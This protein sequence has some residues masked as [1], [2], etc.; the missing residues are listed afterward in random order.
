MSKDPKYIPILKWKAAEMAALANESDKNKAHITPLIELVLPSVNAHKDKE[1]K[2]KKTEEEIHSEMVNKLITKR[3]FEI[4]E[5]IYK[6]W[7]SNEV[8]L[9]VTLLHNKD[10]TNEL[11]I[12][13]LNALTKKAKIKELNIIPVIN[14]ADDHL[15]IDCVI[16]LISDQ[17]IN[18]VCLRITQSSLSDSDV[19]NEK[20]SNF[21]NY[22]NIPKQKI[23]ILIDLKYLNP[24]SEI[25]SDLFDCAQKI[26][27]LKEFKEFIFSSGSFP[28]D[29]SDCS[30]EETAYLPRADWNSWKINTTKKEL[31]R[32]PVYSDYSI[33]H[34]IYNDSLQFFESTST[35][36]YTLESEWMIM[37]GKKRALELYLTHAYLLVKQPEFKNATFGN[38]ARFSWGDNQ[39]SKKA[40][41]F[42][43]Y[44]RDNSVK[45]MGR[46]WDW[47]AFGINHHTAMVMHQ[48][49]N[50]LD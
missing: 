23:H 45:G 11:K 3:F 33:R 1:R 26:Y 7:G 34:P 12:D 46:T 36:K 20:I 41:H 37:K 49:S 50:P 2:K 40:Q 47:I 25:Y 30:L 48:L 27:K 13:A 18:E 21:I 22:I 38:G 32:V 29:M 17:L 24:E 35:L 28:I 44:R 14:L 43:V 8:Y 10:K 4:P 42:E 15:I 5:E 31:N 16:N 9:D 39:I 19:L 6:F